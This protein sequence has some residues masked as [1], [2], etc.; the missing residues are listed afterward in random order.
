MEKSEIDALRERLR[1]AEE[2]LAAIREG[3]VDAFIVTGKR[4]EAV[5]TLKSVERLADTI[6][7]QSTEAL[8]VC[9]EHGRVQR[10]S[11]SAQ[12]LCGKNPE[13]QPFATMFPLRLESRPFDLEQVRAGKILRAVEVEFAGDPPRVLLLTA[14]PLWLAELGPGALVGMVDVTERYHAE[15]ALRRS[16]VV[17]REARRM[18]AIGRLAGGIAHEFNNALTA[19][20]G[21]AELALAAA[22]GPPV[23]AN[24]H[25]VR[26]A[27]KRL[28]HLTSRLLS[29]ASKQMV[30]AKD[31][32]LDGLVAS[33]VPELRLRLPTTIELQVVTTG[34]PLPV[35]LD[36][37]E[38][39]TAVLQLVLNAR[40]AMPAGGR[41]R[42]ETRLQKVAQP[43]FEGLFEVPAGSYAVLRVA[44]SG[45][46]IDPEV[47]ARLFEPFFTTKPFGKNS[48]LGL[49]IVYGVVK[50]AR[51][52]I[53][54]ESEPGAGSQ[55]DVY[56]PLHSTSR[57]GDTGTPDHGK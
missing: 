3:R 17:V 50:Q 20:L 43:V 10:A 32:D 52:Y 24:L 53:L 28:A 40:D 27:G 22:P 45:R 6:F 42:L 49:A 2:T 36:R 8:V 25:E 56:L 29:L 9:D 1:E 51:G 39:H 35:Y 19:L 5:L 16:R 13:L 4:G 18:E 15:D 57:A 41:L 23:A 44:D 26:I 46:G 37:S 21:H 12:E 7:E 34:V 47:L 33:V 38:M 11:L 55:F 30:T 54:V 14:Q 48:G 31:D